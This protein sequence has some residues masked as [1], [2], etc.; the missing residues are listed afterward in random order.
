MILDEVYNS[1]I[2]VT[3]SSAISFVVLHQVHLAPATTFKRVTTEFRAHIKLGLTATM[4][5]EV[6]TI[7]SLSYH[8]RAY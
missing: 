6:R 7:V 4:V 3:H 5:R 1:L 8:L 2:F